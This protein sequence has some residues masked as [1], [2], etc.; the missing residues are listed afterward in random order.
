MMNLSSLSKARFILAVALITTV[1]NV[2]FQF[3]GFSNAWLVAIAAITIALNILTHVLIGIADSNLRK[4]R[5]FCGKLAKGNLEERLFYPLEKSGSIEDVRLA[6]NHFVDL[7]DAFLR[8]ARYA[9]DATCRN[10]FYRTIITRGLLGNFVQTADIINRANDASGKKNE[11]IGQ[12]IKVIKEI[13]GTERHTSED[14]GSA[15]AQGIESIAA[16]TEESSVSIAEINRQ[17]TDASTHTKD[18]EEKAEDLERAA[19]T[20]EQTTGKIT[21]IITLIRGIAEQTNLLALNATIEAARAGDAGKGFSVVASEVKK[22]ANETAVATQSIVDLMVNINAAVESTTS[23]VDGL[24]DVIVNINSTTN[25]IATAI[26]QQG[27][28]SREIAKSATMVSEGLHV[29]AQ[30]VDTITEITKKTDPSLT[31]APSNTYS[32]AA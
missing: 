9:T 17:V 30:R 8:E 21:E 3:L 15:A 24:R 29:I 28:A 22:L 13:V 31:S 6:I 5:S 23:D 2:L 27:F 1:I 20:L 16:A 10:H 19:K 14:T 25:S 4:I 11:A 32:D 7:T 12:L 26:E 18:A